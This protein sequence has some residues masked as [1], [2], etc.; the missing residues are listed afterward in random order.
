VWDSEGRC[1]AEVLGEVW[2]GNGVVVRAESGL[3]EMDS[4]KGL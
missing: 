3:D 4:A 1:E 2:R